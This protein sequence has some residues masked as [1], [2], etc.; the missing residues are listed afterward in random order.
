MY[1]GV[2]ER[3]PD[4]Q[5]LVLECGG[6]WIAHWMD[7]FDEFL[8]AYDWALTAPLSLTPSEYFRRNCVISFDPGE[9]TMGRDGRPRGRGQPHLG[10]RLPALRREVSRVS[11]TSCLERVEDLTAERQ[12]KIVGANAARVYRIEDKY[13]Q[14]ARQAQDVHA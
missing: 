11:S 2:F 6:G 13:E 5:V 3:H 4:L 7:R 12:R 8:E 14:R 9:R 1:G 10:E